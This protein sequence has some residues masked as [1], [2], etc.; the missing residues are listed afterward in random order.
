MPNHTEFANDMDSALGKVSVAVATLRELVDGFE[1]DRRKVALTA[2]VS[3]VEAAVAEAD[4]VV[5]AARRA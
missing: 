4:R 2:T 5:E 3:A 1:H